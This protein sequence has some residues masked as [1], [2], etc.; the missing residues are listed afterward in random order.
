MDAPGTGVE[1]P[2]PGE[3]VAVINAETGGNWADY[4]VVPADA[5]LGVPDDLP[6]QQAACFFINPASALLML[7]YVLAVPR[8]DGCSSRRPDQSWDA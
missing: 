1:R 5:L 8:G 2:I 4:A 3:R 6:D 7:R